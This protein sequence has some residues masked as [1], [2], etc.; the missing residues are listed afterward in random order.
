[1]TIFDPD[2]SIHYKEPIQGHT[3]TMSFLSSLAGL[4]EWPE[5]VKDLFITDTK[6][7][8]GIIGVKLYIR[9]KPWVITIDEY[10]WFTTST[11]PHKLL[12][13]REAADDKAIWGAI[14]EKA[15]AKVK[16]SY[17]NTAKSDLVKNGLSQVTGVPVFEKS[18]SNNTNTSALYEELKAA[19]QAGYIMTA[20][21]FYPDATE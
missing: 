13:A 14:L 11:T 7:S 9:G 2:G 3:N 15:L 8:A 19:D 6:N 21:L 10:H 17:Y 16:G 4:T 5:L 20:G 18:T 12:F 1:M